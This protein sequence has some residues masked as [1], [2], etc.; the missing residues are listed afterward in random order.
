MER[1]G[2]RRGWPAARAVLASAVLA[3]AV[4]GLGTGAAAQAPARPPTPPPDPEAVIFELRLG[5]IE[6]RTTAMYRRGDTLLV[7]VSVF[8][9]LAELK[10]RVAADGAVTGLL[11][12]GGR[13]LRLPA[14]AGEAIAADRRVTVEPHETWTA[15]DERYVATRVLAALFDVVWLVQANDLLVTVPEIG[16][17]PIGERLAREARRRTL[18]RQLAGP[19]PPD[20]VR[21]PDAPLLD[22]LVLDYT[23]QAT[24]APGATLVGGTMALGAHVLGGALTSAWTR[25]AALGASNQP[26]RASWIGAWHDRP[27]LRQLRLGDA[28]GTGP[29]A[30]FARGVAITNTP[31]L[32]PF[33]LGQVGFAGMLPEGWTV[34]A[35]QG[36]RLVGFDSLAAR[37]RWG[38]PLPVAF[39]ENLLDFVATGPFGEVRRF[40]RA[41]RVLTD[42][43]PAGTVE[44]GVSAGECLLQPCRR[45]L[46]ADVRWG[47]STRLTL[48]A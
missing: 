44:Y 6:S 21:P 12:P 25:N 35:F 33:V 15:D 5:R 36:D 32:R 2:R 13:P 46:N 14:G 16:T 8:C 10:C 34:E 27:W 37:G 22:G 47:V 29:S 18:R 7:P 4:L 42:M 17:L 1:P 11:E 40:T 26:W 3:S 38:M 39:G 9:E 28:V 41:Y 43:I 23:V 31:Y 45:T 48:R 30:R 20:A 24:A 19:A